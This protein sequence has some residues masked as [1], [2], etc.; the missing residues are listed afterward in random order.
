M[1]STTW[2]SGAPPF[3]D[4]VRAYTLLVCRTARRCGVPP[5]DVDD[6][7]QKVIHR[8]YRAILDGRLDASRPR[9]IGGWLKKTTRSVARDFLALAHT[10]HE[11]LTTT[12][13]LDRTAG[14]DHPENRM[15]ENIDVHEVID[16]ILDKLPPEQREVFVM[17]DLEDTP[18]DEI[19]D[20]LKIPSSTAY[21]RLKAARATFAREWKAMQTS[22][23]VVAPLALLTLHELIAAEHTIPDV[24][25]DFV[26]ELLRRL[27]EE[28]GQDFLTGPASGAVAA[29]ISAKL[30]AAAGAA[31]AAGVTLTTWQIGLG[32]LLVGIAAAS[33]TAALRPAG[34][35]PAPPTTITAHVLS[36]VTPAPS[37]A[38]NSAHVP[39]GGALT[40]AK[41]SA[42][43]RSSEIQTKLLVNARA[44]V[45]GHKPATALALLSRV[46]ASDLAEERDDLRQLALAQLSDAGQP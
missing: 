5:V 46:T 31:K 22:G 11:S 39:P 28:L 33:L 19:L 12:G 27:G 16:R 20:E 21:S 3:P 43:P 24:P 29:G 8:F 30:G 14:A 18:M 44:L 2:P 36:P 13:V 42:P 35:A 26:D 10:Q 4:L 37:P 15:A 1:G 17:S 23:A 45:N 7:A 34:A 41:L 40:E 32:I 38:I 9:G 6:C 25:Q